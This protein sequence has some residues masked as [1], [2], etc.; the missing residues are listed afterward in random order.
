[1]S[2]TANPSQWS[3]Q[4]QC[5]FIA[6]LYGL[7]GGALTTILY[8]Q[9]GDDTVVQWRE[10]V[11]H[12]HQKEYF[13]QG[14]EK[15]GVDP[16]TEPHAVVA[17]KYHYFSNSLGGIDMEMFVESPK[18]AW[19]RYNPPFGPAGLAWL[20][21]KPRMG[22]AIFAGWHPYNGVRLDNPR[23]GF[24]LSKAFG[25]GEPYAEGYFYEYDH[26]LADEERFQ[27]DPN[28]TMPE[29]DPERAPKLDAEVWPPDR[30]SKAL[31]NFGR[32]YIEES[33]LAM[34]QVIG[35]PESAHLV[36]RAF[37]GVA[38]QYGKELLAELGIAGRDAGSLALFTKHLCDMAGDE[39]ELSSPEPDRHVLRVHRRRLFE[40]S[41]SSA[42]VMKGM[43]GFTH[44]LGRMLG[45]RVRTTLT[46]MREEGSPYDE[47]VFEDAR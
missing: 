24:V 28:S 25:D 9:Q 33:V 3:L 18:K 23:L 13:L 35:T 29:F 20:A 15:L 14:L 37:E 17:A 10:T 16:K 45:P 30:R 11:L 31:R 27:F 7:F 21:V 47:I 34:Q 5:E 26:D 8:S 43:F 2:P 1:M 44:M 6:K 36:K 32:G 39:A 19:I 46:A 40:G 12:L 42:E 4:E 22:R 38:L 41:S